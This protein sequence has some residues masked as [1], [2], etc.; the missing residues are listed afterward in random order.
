[1]SQFILESLPQHLRARQ[2]AR[3][4]ERGVQVFCILLATV[5]V[6][7]AGFLHK[8]IN[9]IRKAHQLVIDPSSLAGLPPDLA[10]LGKMGTFRALAI[11][12]AS[13]R[14][15]RLKMEGKNY[16][17]MEL[18]SIICKLAPRFPK[19][20]ANAAWNMAYNISVTEFLPQA[21]W[22]WVSNGIKL[23]RDSGLQY[24]P[25]SVTLYR[26]LAW[27]Y[28]H[29][30]GDILDDH[31]LQ[32]KK[33]LAVEMELVLGA[34]PVTT[35]DD[36]YFVWFKKIVD[37]PRDWNDFIDGDEE[38]QLL[39]KRFHALNIEPDLLLLEFVA[40]FQR[41]ELQAKELLADQSQIDVMLS[42][43]VALLFDADVAIVLD[44]LLAALR[45]RVMRED[46][47][48]DL[49][50]M[51][52]LM[53][54]RYGPLDWRNAFSHTL[55]WASLGDR[56]TQDIQRKDMADSVNNARIVLFSLQSIVMR[57]RIVLWPNFIDP[58]SSYVDLTPDVRFIP[59]L[60]D[61]YMRISKEQF[62]DD[63]G[64]E[65]GFPA[66]NYMNG[67]VTNMENWTQ[68]LF[69]E[70]GEANLKIAENYYTWLREKN[71]HPD[72]TIQSRYTKTLEGFVM[73]DILNQLNTSRAASGM[74]RTLLKR[75]F[76]HLGLGQRQAGQAV[77]QRAQLCHAY[78]HKYAG[79]AVR[80]DRI[81]LDPISIMARNELVQFMK[82]QS[83][84]PLFKARLWQELPLEMR[85]AAYDDLLPYAEKLCAVQQPPWSLQS[86]LSE[87][88][89]MAGFRLKRINAV[90][91][92]RKEGV[93][94]GERFKK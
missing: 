44:R 30:I 85:Q 94:V 2:A 23:L 83:I 34:P 13:I 37:A 55:Y 57:G 51:Y 27:I 49:D 40:R 38:V 93:E 20:W 46:L 71:L 65:Y 56:V 3:R 24:N 4:Y 39:I 75:G 26:E 63:P 22:Q 81:K 10:L 21:R 60:Y 74:I 50:Y 89:G 66:E 25:R 52:E 7:A 42:K 58:M 33:S 14:A 31:H 67:F 86:M 43:Q 28:W 32:Y 17:A 36:E 1:M 47:K 69:L 72:G 82:E 90:G 19:V 8:P 59:Y 18:H 79:D 12:W 70:G 77:F 5:C 29:K 92:Q 61:E 76:K 62:P 87:P 80:T 41:P 91:E 84:S 9:E 15:N 88:P 68:L 6:V 53:A 45:S 54:D 48:F 11:D 73:D 35:T 78:W 16:E 64:L